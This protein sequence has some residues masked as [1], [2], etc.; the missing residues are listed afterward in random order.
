MGDVTK[1]SRVSTQSAQQRLWHQ[2]RITQL[3]RTC[4]G[5]PTIRSARKQSVRARGMERNHGRYDRTQHSHRP[6]DCSCIPDAW[7][8]F[9]C[10]G[11]TSLPCSQRLRVCLVFLGECRG[12]RCWAW[13]STTTPV[14]SRGSFGHRARARAG[15]VGGGLPAK[16]AAHSFPSALLQAGCV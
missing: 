7:A 13:S 8:R 12:C 1:T 11:I 6:P 5:R 4:E 2:D 3:G 10:L 14:P 9:P 15:R 16:P